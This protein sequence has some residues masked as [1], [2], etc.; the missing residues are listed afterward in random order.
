LAPSAEW[1]GARRW[2]FWSEWNFSGKIFS[3]IDAPAIFFSREDKN[4]NDNK[5][6]KMDFYDDDLNFSEIDGDLRTS[7]RSN[8]NFSLVRY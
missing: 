2:C 3:K 6:R 1:N 4:L 8:E 5:K 7:V